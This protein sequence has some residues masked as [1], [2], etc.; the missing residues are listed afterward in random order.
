MPDEDRREVAL[1]RILRRILTGRVRYNGRSNRG[2]VEFERQPGWI[3]PHPVADPETNLTNHERWVLAGLAAGMDCND[4][5]EIL[6][7]SPDSARK[8]FGRAKKKLGGRTRAHTIAIAM[9]RNL[10]I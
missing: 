1:L 5:A 4:I 7:S 8:A 6:G 2:T 9:R 3:G 10:I